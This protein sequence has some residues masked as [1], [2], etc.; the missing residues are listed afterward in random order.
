M[1][2]VPPLHLYFALH[3]Y[4]LSTPRISETINF[5]QFKWQLELV[6]LIFN[7]LYQIKYVCMHACMH[8]CMHV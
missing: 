2:N 1:Y 3:I 8:V 4:A 6:A 5:I 7:L